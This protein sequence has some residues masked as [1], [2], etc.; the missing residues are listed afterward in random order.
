MKIR[1]CILI[2]LL[3]I[4]IG[5]GRALPESSENAESSGEEFLL[6]E[7]GA[8]RGGER[9][10]PEE[11]KNKVKVIVTAD[12]LAGDEEADMVKLW[13]NVKITQLGILIFSRKAT[14]RMEK[15]IFELSGDVLFSRPDTVIRGDKLVLY[16]LEQKG[17]WEGNV[18]VIQQQSQKEKKDDLKQKYKVS[19]APV[20]LYCDRLDF[21]WGNEVKAI[22]KGNVEA[23]QKENNLYSDKAVYTENPQELVL[24]GNIELENGQ[25]AK[26]KCDKLTLDIKGEKV[27]AKGLKGQGGVIEINIPLKKK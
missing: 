5:A 26:F 8:V 13:D 17:Y 12:F 23:H 10:I 21:F 2:F 4:F 9:V 19:D 16:Q 15:K 1:L 3:I 6:L 22:A 18:K 24:E 20:V 25:G 11:A 7:A 27:D 14:Y